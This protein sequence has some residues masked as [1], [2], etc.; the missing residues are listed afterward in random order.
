M[1]NDVLFTS[2]EWDTSVTAS[3]GQTFKLHGC[4]ALCDSGY[5][6]WQETM[7]AMKHPT[8]VNEAR[9]SSRC[10]SVRKIIERVFGMLK[11]RFRILRLPMLVKDMAEVEDI[12]KVC[13][14]LHNMCLQVHEYTYIPTRHTH[15]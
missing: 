7:C 11:K 14:V 13:C 15:T 4:M 8:S 1:R 2:C 3:N 6:K 9:F 5:H 10:E 12:V